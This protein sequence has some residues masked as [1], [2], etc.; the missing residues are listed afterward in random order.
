MTASPDGTN[1]KNSNLNVLLFAVT[2]LSLLL[3]LGAAFWQAANPK[4]DLNQVKSELRDDLIKIESRIDKSI[5]DV[6]YVTD[7]K[8]ISKDEHVEFALRLNKDID[9]LRDEINRLRNDL[10][11]RSEHAQHWADT[12]DRIA[13]IHKA[14]S[15]FIRDQTATNDEMRKEFGGTYTA[16]DQ[17]RNLQEQIKAMQLRVDIVAEK[18]QK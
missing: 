12:E 11:S 16:G 8:M 17:L 7:N 4:G 14:M 5:S 18:P 3:S 6:K 10:V 2:A 9:V 1:G 13:T 15:D